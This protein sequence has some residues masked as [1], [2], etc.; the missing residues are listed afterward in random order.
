MLPD[1]RIKPRIPRRAHP[2]VEG[3]DARDYANA[4]NELLKRLFVH[5]LGIDAARRVSDQR[6]LAMLD[7]V[8]GEPAFTRGPGQPLGEARFTPAPTIDAAALE[9]LMTRLLATVSPR[10]RGRLAEQPT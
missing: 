6:W 8:L 2:L 10:L 1:R 4:C 5:G 9:A 3:L 7:A